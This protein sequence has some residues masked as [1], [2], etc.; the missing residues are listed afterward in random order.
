MCLAQ[1]TATT[2]PSSFVSIKLV[3]KS[4]VS[5]PNAVVSI[6]NTHANSEHELT[7]AIA[8][9]DQIDYQY[10][11]EVLIVD[12]NQWVDFPNSDNVRHHV[13]SFSSPKTFEIKMYAGSDAQPIQFNTG[14]IVVLG[15]NIHDSMVGYIYVSEN[16]TSYLSDANGKLVLPANTSNITIWH[17]NLSANHVERKNYTISRNISEQTLTLDM[18]INIAQST[19]NLKNDGKSNSFRNKFKRFD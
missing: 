9:M 6:P 19:D 16:E 11:P 4:G 1:V 3:D 10:A 14:G 12:K 2:K 13:Y 7:Q 18:L 5:V 15:C 8:I 17:P